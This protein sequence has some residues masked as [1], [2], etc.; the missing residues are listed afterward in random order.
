MSSQQ[1]LLDC[2]GKEKPRKIKWLKNEVRS[3]D[4]KYNNIELNDDLI[5]Y[6][7]HQEKEEIVISWTS[8]TNAWAHGNVS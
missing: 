8:Y 2:D 5:D 6:G 4:F 7:V 3:S 1:V